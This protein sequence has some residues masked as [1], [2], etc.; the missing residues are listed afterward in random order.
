MIE[1]YKEF[2]RRNL[3]SMMILQVHD[4]LL[5]EVVPEEK[6]IVARIVKEKMEGIYP[7]KVPLIVDMNYGKNWAEAH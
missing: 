5:F 7:L 1:I 3:K 6:D 4:E 2:K